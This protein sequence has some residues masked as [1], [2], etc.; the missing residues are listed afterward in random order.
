MRH[1]TTTERFLSLFTTLR[2]EEGSGA[3]RLSLQAFLILFAYYLLKVI[4]EPMILADGSAEL[5]A[6]TTAIQAGVL[7]L[8]VPIFAK[9]YSG[10]SNLD[11]KHHLMRRILLFFII[12]LFA[13][14]LCY[15]LGWHIGIT[16]Y[17]WLGIFSVMVLALFWSFAADL[18]NLKSGQRIFP[19]IAAA[20]AL[21]AYLGAKMA[22]WL[23]PLVGHDGVMYT[24]ACLLLVPWWMSKRVEK[25]IPAGSES[26]IDDH[27]EEPSA[28]ALEG[29]RVVLRSPYLILIAVFVITLNLI[30]T[31]GEYILAR[32]ITEQASMLASS[33]Q[34][35]GSQDDFITAFYSSYLAWFTLI[36]FLIQ[37]FL[38][39]RIFDRIGVRGALLVLPV[40]MVASYSLILL[41]PV[42]A[43]VR[44]SMIV[45]NSINY[46]LQNTT[47]HALFLPVNREEKYIGKHVI[48]TF[49]FRIG[50]LLSAAAV[51]VGSAMLGVGI[52]GFV[53]TNI[54]LAVVL[55]GL[56]RAIGQRNAGVIKEN[57]GNLPPV[58]AAPL[59]DMDIPAGE[60]TRFTIQ[61]GTFVDP[62]EGDALKY[63]AF[64]EELGKLP[65]W[66]KFDG[67]KGIFHFHPPRGQEGAIEIRVVARDFDGL[68]ADARFVVSYSSNG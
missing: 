36:S 12:N 13:L 63:R 65:T 30:N 17:V 5:K 22:G 3:V 64:T 15:R 1:Y 24:S 50:D 59:P 38:V 60:I 33:G 18:Y 21:G 56:S 62:D 8:I 49:F 48:D 67:L 14:G 42:L 34:L 37:L 45:E 4:R 20:G 44:A 68:E 57:L 23:D 9:L 47:R 29:F 52:L 61:E 19:L 6:Y 53:G 46:S 41:F 11:G 10:V 43:L 54:V 39:S 28:S 26:Y 58:L 32:F 51:F 55:F 7:M 31:N 66:I 25:T 40:V 2:P 27:Q 35:V 16:F